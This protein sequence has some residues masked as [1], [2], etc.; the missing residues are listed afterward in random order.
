MLKLKLQCFG[1]LMGKANS[2]EKTLMLGKS[3]GK[4]RRGWQGMRWLV[5]ITNSMGLNL[6]KLWERVEDRG[7]WCAAVLGVSKN[8]TIKKVE[9]WGNYVFK[10]WCWRSLLRVSWTTKKSNQS[11]LK[12]INPEYSL[13]V[14]MCSWSS[15]TLAT[16]WKEQT[17]WNWKRPWSWEKQKAKGDG[18]SRGWDGWM[19]LLTQWTW[20]CTNSGR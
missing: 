5:S 6:S 4:R 19:A 20:I 9:H 17:H 8:W 12:E 10:L 2:L 16:W 13:K 14:M 15:N 1:H 11:I 18:G 7:D 3:E